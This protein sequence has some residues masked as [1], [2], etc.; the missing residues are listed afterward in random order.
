[1]SSFKK[2]YFDYST[3]TAIVGNS[4]VG[5]EILSCLKVPLFKTIEIKATNE[6]NG[7]YSSWKR[8]VEVN[9]DNVFVITKDN[10]PYGVLIGPYHQSLKIKSDIYPIDYDFHPFVKAFLKTI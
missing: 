3:T 2:A 7:F 1:M 9:H 8:P 4:I 10:V 6:G 5:Y